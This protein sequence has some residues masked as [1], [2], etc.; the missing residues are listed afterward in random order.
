MLFFWVD[1]NI[2]Q[3]SK[4]LGV[5][6][7]HLTPPSQHRPFAPILKLIKLHFLNPPRSDYLVC[8]K[9]LAL[10]LASLVLLVI[11]KLSPYFNI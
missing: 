10:T 11:G 7:P 3:H 8:S 9:R 4:T 6:T 2:W 5:L 1:I